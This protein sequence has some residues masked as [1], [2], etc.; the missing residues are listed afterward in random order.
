MTNAILSQILSIPK[1]KAD[2]FVFSGSWATILM[3]SLK[4][5]GITVV[6]F[7]KDLAERKD[8]LTISNEQGQK[9]VIALKAGVSMNVVKF[10]KLIRIPTK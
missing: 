1:S 10:K 8:L 6:D 2:G 4:E 5:V 9:Q 7:R 3:W